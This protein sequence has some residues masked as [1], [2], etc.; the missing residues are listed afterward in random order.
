MFRSRSP[1]PLGRSGHR[2]HLGPRDEPCHSLLPIC[3]T[4]SGSRLCSKP[5]PAHSVDNERYANGSNL[6]NVSE[7]RQRPPA[8]RRVKDRGSLHSVASTFQIHPSPVDCLAT[9]S[10]RHARGWCSRATSSEPSTARSANRNPGLAGTRCLNVMMG[11]PRPRSHH[12]DCV[13]RW[14]QRSVVT[15][16]ERSLPDAI[17]RPP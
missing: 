9:S 3:A 10:Q 6:P 13:N 5:V 4:E 14:P 8:S 15:N 2:C 7:L 17:P 11:Q 16:V 1:L 12:A